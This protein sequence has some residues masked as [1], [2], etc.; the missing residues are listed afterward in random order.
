MSVLTAA[1]AA[2]VPLLSMAASVVASIA[3][4]NIKIGDY[5]RSD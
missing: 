5:A 4:R 2:A 1:A 3:L